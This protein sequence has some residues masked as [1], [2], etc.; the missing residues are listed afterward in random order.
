MANE[1]N[2]YDIS[3][4][5]ATM[6]II[7]EAALDNLNLGAN[8]TSGVFGDVIL[9]PIPKY[10]RAQNEKTYSQGN[11]HIVLGRD[12]PG[13]RASGYGGQGHT[14][15]S[16]IDLVVGRG[17]PS[18]DATTNVDPNFRSDGARIYIS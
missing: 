1:I 17:G 18:P 13:S 4:F 14:G 6:R 7:A 2:S 16:S 11:S 8:T 12:R 15:A 3:G 5:P 10:I 9:E